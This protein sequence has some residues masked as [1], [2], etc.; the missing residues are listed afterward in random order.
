MRKRQAVLITAICF[1]AF[2][3]SGCA[4]ALIG[5]GAG[6]VAYV[7]GSLKAVLDQDVDHVYQATLK[8]LKE[9][10]I[11]PTQKQKDALSAL[12]VGRTSADKKIKIKLK[13]VESNLTQLSIKIGVFGDQAQSQVVY[14]K[15]K[16]NL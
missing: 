12:V 3:A 8:T 6:T 1:S 5:A 13:A 4:V 11:L 14:D 2:F 9:L 10:E 7:K 15:I 16:E